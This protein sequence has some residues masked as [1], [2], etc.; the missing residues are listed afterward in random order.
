[1]MTH[2]LKSLV[3]SHTIFIRLYPDMFAL[4][5]VNS[6]Y[7]SA[8]TVFRPDLKGKPVIVL[9]NNDGCVIARSAEAK[10]LGIKMGEP[11]FKVKFFCEQNRVTVFSSNYALYADMSSRVMS[12][13]EQN[14]PSIEIYSIDEAFLD[15]TGIDHYQAFEQFGHDVRN[16][17]KQYTKLT[18]GVGIAPTKTLAKLANYAAKKWV[19]TGGVVVL[20]DP[21]RLA[22]LMKIT[23]VDEVWG[24]GRRIS[25]HL[26][27][28]GIKTV[29][30]LAHADISFIRRHFS[31]VLERTVR[32]L[33]GE[34][35]LSLEE[36]A[37]AKKQI[38]VS[39]SFGQKINDYQS[40]KEAI[41]AHAER[42][43]EKLRSE[44]RYCKQVSA[45]IRTSAFNERNPYYS[46]VATSSITFPSQDTRDI[47]H[48]ATEA[49]NM[50]WRE[51]FQY[52]KAGIMLGDFYDSK[53]PQYD[54]F[55]DYH[56]SKHSEPLMK[57][58]DLINASGR[59]VWFAGQGVKKNWEMKRGKLSPAYTTK[60]SDIPIVKC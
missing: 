41:C 22:K 9:S 14:A 52:H 45:F 25:V 46:N 31:V 8:Q 12:V 20:N 33:N 35:C 3:S 59:K 51:G 4:V 47:I 44:E 18:V 53:N 15:I 38:V 2:L 30:D 28:L 32:E 26:N 40:V 58:L 54:L 7:A 27:E 23:P 29:Y 13:L 60:L 42:A 43:A 24:V 49:L 57:T 36:I 48:A 50:I 34:S 16:Q 17:V 21:D 10:K 19:K 6:F 11:F 1:M 55:N 39:R 56:E 37:P 5:D